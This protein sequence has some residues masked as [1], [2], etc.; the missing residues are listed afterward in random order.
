MPRTAGRRPGEGPAPAPDELRAARREFP[1]CEICQF[2]D[3]AGA[4]EATAVPTPRFR[5]TG[6]TVLA[7][8]ATVAEPAGLLRARPKPG[9]PRRDRTRPRP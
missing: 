8:T 7:C 1:H 6:L 4:P 9:L 2:H 5:Y 3:A